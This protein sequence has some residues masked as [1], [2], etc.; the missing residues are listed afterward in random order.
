MFHTINVGA[1]VSWEINRKGEQICG[2]SGS[3]RGDSYVFFSSMEL[4]NLF[5]L[6]KQSEFTSFM[7]PFMGIEQ[8]PF[9][10]FLVIF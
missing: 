6:K 3:R 2:N 7:Y 10:G 8:A 1:R 4:N 5:M 9:H